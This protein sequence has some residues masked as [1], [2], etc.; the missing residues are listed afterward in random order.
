MGK[1]AW[2]RS[3]FRDLV[4]WDRRARDYCLTFNMSDASQGCLADLA[5]F[6][7]A[8]ESTFD[9]KQANRDLMLVMEGRRQV[10]QHINQYLHLTQ[11][12][13]AAILFGQRVFPEEKP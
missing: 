3:R 1:V 12:Q 11:A 8:L 6:C 13:Q 7:G 5:E 10:W 9:P 4:H 2:L